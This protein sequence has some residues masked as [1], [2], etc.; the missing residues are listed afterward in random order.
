M[1][2]FIQRTLGKR[3]IPGSVSDI[4]SLCFTTKGRDNDLQVS[5]VKACG[6]L[7]RAHQIKSVGG[8]KKVT[9]KSLAT[10]TDRSSTS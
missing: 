3:S 6:D 4:S 10:L 1:Q 2:C 8:K 9:G 7:S 5:Q